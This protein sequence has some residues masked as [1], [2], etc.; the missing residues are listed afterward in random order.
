MTTTT[1]SHIFL[2]AIPSERKNKE[3]EFFGEHCAYP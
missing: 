2:K 1:L 3:P